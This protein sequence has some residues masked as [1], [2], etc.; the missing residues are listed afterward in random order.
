MLFTPEV[1]NLFGTRF[2]FWGRQFSHELGGGRW[3]R[4]D[5][6]TLHL[7]YP[8]F[9]LL[10]SQLHLR[11][12]SI[13][14]LRLGTSA[15]HSPAH[16]FLPDLD[17]GTKFTLH[18]LNLAHVLQWVSGLIAYLIWIDPLYSWSLSSNL[19]R[20]TLSPLHFQPFHSARN[21]L[22]LT[23][24]CPTTIQTQLMAHWNELHTIPNIGRMLLSFS[25]LGFNF[26]EMCVMICSD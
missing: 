6:S 4:D 8:L 14:S 18:L 22:L 3:F 2:G 5:L 10:L 9:L 7:L 23:I 11:S 16:R 21:Q 15:S 25:E 20:L 17:L 19:F 24:F 13:R 1:P 26:Y 12:S